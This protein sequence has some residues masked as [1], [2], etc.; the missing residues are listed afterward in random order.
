M[1]INLPIIGRCFGIDPIR[2]FVVTIL[3]MTQDGVTDHIGR[4][5]VVP[6]ILGL[7]QQGF[8]IHVLSA[9]K[10]GRE[11]LIKQY[12]RL[13]DVVGI[14][15]TQVRYRN[16][17][18]V[19]GQ[20]L[21]QSSMKSAARRIVNNES[22]KLIHCRSFPPVM[23]ASK[24]KSILGIKY[25]FDFRDFYANSGLRKKRGLARLVFRRLKQLE[26]PMIRHADKVVCLTER[27]KVVLSEWYLKDVKNSSSYFKVI[28]CCADF[29]LFDPASVSSQ[30]LAR[31]R[32]TAKITTDD[33]VLLYLGSL[34]PDYLLKEMLALFGQ[35]MAIQRRPRFLFVSN[36]GAE[37]VHAECKVQSIP[38]EYIRFVSVDR[39]EVPSFIALANLSVVFISSDVSKNGC[40]PTKLAELFACNIPVIANTGVGDLDNILALQRNGSV[41]VK[42][43]SNDSLRTAAEQV[44]AF[45]LS[46]EL[47]IRDNSREFALEEGVARYSAVYRE[48]L[49]S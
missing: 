49:K 29:N 17:P 34:G 27:A 45:K 2:I 41:I 1:L 15:W 26:G 18:S 24:L 32:E 42:D 6:Y 13:F 25:I 21:T 31:A 4:S 35:I 12:Q 33:F 46:G 44:V 19:L 43:F 20:L 16:K 14:R 48:L 11:E 23:I 22:I 7:A 37:M 39:E 8:Q 30:D 10:A 9:E 40:S 5:Q 28:P 47:S 38:L 3:Y 36:N